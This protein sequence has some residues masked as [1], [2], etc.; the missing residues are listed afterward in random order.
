VTFH[1]LESRTLPLAAKHLAKLKCFYVRE[2]FGIKRFACSVVSGSSFVVA[3]MIV[4]GGLH[5]R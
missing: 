2:E 1:L 4:T 5:G 3:H